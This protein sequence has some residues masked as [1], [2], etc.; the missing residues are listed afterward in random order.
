MAKTVFI[1]GNPSLGIL[2]TIVT[3]AFL[4]LIFNHKH[5]GLNQDGSAPIDE[6]AQHDARRIAHFIGRR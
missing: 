4:N 2:G 6:V 1:D 5:D 3:A